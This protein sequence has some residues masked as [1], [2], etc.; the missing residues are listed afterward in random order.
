MGG[1]QR[2][3]G[4]SDAEPES[5]NQ[6]TGHGPNPERRRGSLYVAPVPVVKLVIGV[7]VGWIIILGVL[8]WLLYRA[9]K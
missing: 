8:V 1:G 6:A 4:R 9:R 5:G 7:S 3:L 2:I